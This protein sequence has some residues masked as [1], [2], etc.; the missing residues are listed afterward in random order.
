MWNRPSTKPRPA[1]QALRNMRI[2]S[3]TPVK[4]PVEKVQKMTPEKPLKNLF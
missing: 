2:I 1:S 4:T 3:K